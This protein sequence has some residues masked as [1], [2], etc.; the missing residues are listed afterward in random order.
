[1]SQ[2]RQLRAWRHDRC[3]DTLRL[4]KRP[5]QQPSTDLQKRGSS[6]TPRSQYGIDLRRL[7]NL[8]GIAA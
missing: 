3:L 6:P 5:G 8:A 1:V 4:E 2:S 7:A